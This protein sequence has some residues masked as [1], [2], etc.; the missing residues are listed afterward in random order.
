MMVYF[1]FHRLCVFVVLTQK[2][3]FD[4]AVCYVRITMYL[5]INTSIIYVNDIQFRR[6]RKYQRAKWVFV[7]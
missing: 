1:F 4:A 5:A 2:L 7:V 3:Y 6:N